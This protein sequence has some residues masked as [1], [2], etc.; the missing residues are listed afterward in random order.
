MLE[1]YYKSKY[2]HSNIISSL[3]V[4]DSPL[5]QLSYK[6]ENELITEEIS[7]TLVVLCAQHRKLYRTSR[8]TVSQTVDI[9]Q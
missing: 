7:S 6:N 4:T 5:K 2:A 1:S 8:V 9:N 3:I